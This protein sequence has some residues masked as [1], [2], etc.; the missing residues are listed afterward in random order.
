MSRGRRM[1]ER[2]GEGRCAWSIDEHEMVQRFASSILS[3]ARPVLANF[4]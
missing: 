4:L 3:W 1:R 2:N